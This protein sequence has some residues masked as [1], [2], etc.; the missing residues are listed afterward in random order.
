VIRFTDVAGKKEV[1][2]LSGQKA[3]LGLAL[4]PDGERLGWATSTGKVGVA[5]V[6]KLM[7][8]NAVV[9]EKQP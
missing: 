4:S 7:K 5:G 3:L 1:A 9:E 6:E 8:D 2:R